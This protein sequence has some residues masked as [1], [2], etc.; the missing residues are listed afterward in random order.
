MKY[1]LLFL[2]LLAAPV[3]N[4]NGKTNEGVP[5]QG[6]ITLLGHE[7]FLNGSGE[8]SKFFTDVYVAGLYLPNTS[9]QAEAI[10]AANEP[11][12]MRL[13]ITSSIITK[14]MLMSS[15]K[16][17]LKL[18]AGKQYKK[19][20]AMLDEVFEVREFPVNDGDQFDFLY[21]PGEGTHVLYNNELVH[22]VPGFDFKQVLFGIWIGKK[23]VD[24]KLKQ[25][26]LKAANASRSLSI[27]LDMA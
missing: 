6:Q 15:I 21:V 16:D 12:L 8:R 25:K 24:P 9:P 18:S 3:L 27:Q 1:W 7:L 23:P 26:L 2:A 4:A 14:S 17:G 10:I 11:Q 19:Y 20:A 13:N 22:V 5:M